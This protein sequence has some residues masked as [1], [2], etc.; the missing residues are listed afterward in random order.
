MK[1]LVINEMVNMD[2][3]PEEILLLIFKKLDVYHLVYVLPK[4][5]RQF[6]TVALLFYKTVKCLTWER[7]KDKPSAGD[8]F[9]F[10]TLDKTKYVCKMGIQLK[11]TDEN[12]NFLLLANLFG[13]SLK[14]LHL[15]S[16]CKIQRSSIS[17]LPS[18]GIGESLVEFEVNECK[19]TVLLEILVVSSKCF[20]SLEKF[21]IGDKSSSLTRKDDKF[22][23]NYKF[24]N[25]IKDFL[26]SCRC[27]QKLSFTIYNLKL[28]EFGHF[29]LLIGLPLQSLVWMNISSEYHLKAK[30]VEKILNSLENLSPNL[31][32]L[33]LGIS[34]VFKG[35]PLKMELIEN[36]F[37]KLGEEKQIETF[38][39]SF[40][41]FHRLK[42]SLAY[43]QSCIIPLVNFVHLKVLELYFLDFDNADVL[44]AL[45]TVVARL[46]KFVVF[47]IHNLE[48]FLM[49]NPTFKYMNLK[50][51]IIYNCSRVSTECLVNFV[52]NKCP[53][54]LYIYQSI[55]GS[56]FWPGDFILQ[57]HSK[58]HPCSTS[59]C[60]FNSVETYLVIDYPYDLIE[61][62]NLCGLYGLGNN[63]T[64]IH[65]VCV[66]TE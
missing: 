54:L 18:C 46:E 64:F 39:I 23:L 19:I 30:E 11:E 26:T 17:F 38:R 21:T 60:S 27:L 29:R 41:M 45:E 24:K 15:N 34:S 56:T 16:Y 66:K 49:Y 63:K 58:L 52:I 59:C 37:K 4:V 47:N 65:R 10:E 28:P 42:T 5:C 48:S 33:E 31:N 22:L 44:A 36:C 9:I 12:K 50:Y 62:Q 13:E 61:Q 7:D 6:R 43:A 3:L 57:L 40:Q 1:E 35:R 20:T 53:R 25:L 51:L 14:V 32:C 2:K 8:Y 55:Y